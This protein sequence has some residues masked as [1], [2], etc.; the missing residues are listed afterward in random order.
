MQRF[1]QIPWFICFY[2]I[3]GLVTSSITVYIV[4]QITTIEK[5]F[6]LSSTKSGYLMA[7]NDIGYC[8]FVLVASYLANR[9]HVPRF[10]GLSA[11][12]YGVSSIL[13]CVPHFLYKPEPLS[14]VS[15]V[16][17]EVSNAFTPEV[18]TNSSDQE[19]QFLTDFTNNTVSVDIADEAKG[20]NDARSSVAMAFIAIGMIVQ[21]L[22]KAPRA[23]MIA[24]YIDDNSKPRETGFFMGKYVFFS[25]I[26]M[27][28]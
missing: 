24:Q 25:F 21:G 26:H 27:S 13:C 19:L 10:L 11:T 3:S 15:A 17:N 12:L 18:C 8:A 1:A 6:A 5:Q 22:G 7:C 14:G 28:K 2:S 23:P 16:K 20:P 9:V 4:S